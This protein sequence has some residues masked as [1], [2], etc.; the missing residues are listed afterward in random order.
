VHVCRQFRDAARERYFKNMN[1][2]M[3]FHSSIADYYLGIWGGGNP[4][5]FKYT[6]IQRHRSCPLTAYCIIILQFHRLVMSNLTGQ[7]KL[8][9]CMDLWM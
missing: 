4:K 1:M 2:A 8:H 6:E 5:P 3:Y 7:P 9:A